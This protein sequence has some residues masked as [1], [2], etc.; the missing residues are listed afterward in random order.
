MTYDP[1]E[2][3]RRLDV[4]R[5]ISEL[6][7][8]GEERRRAEAERQAA[9]RQVA[10][11]ASQKAIEEKAIKELRVE[12][13]AVW[14]G[15]K[16]SFEAAVKGGLLERLREAKMVAAMSNRASIASLD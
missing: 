5:N 10:Y 2:L 16:E 12:A 6:K 14:P 15:S 4:S 1:A 7:K 13:Y 8:Q 11:E 3:N 9:E